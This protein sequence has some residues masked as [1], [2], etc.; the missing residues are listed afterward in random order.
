[1][2]ARAPAPALEHEPVQPAEEPQGHGL[3][4]RVDLG[5]D[6]PQHRGARA[7]AP[8]VVERGAQQHAVERARH[9]GARLDVEGLDDLGATGVDI[10]VSPRA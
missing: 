2:P 5:V 3:R 6:V 7:T 9:R 1:M 8:D 10:A 4:P